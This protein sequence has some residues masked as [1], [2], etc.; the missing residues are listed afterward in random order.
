MRTLLTIWLLG[1]FSIL[2][3]AQ[4]F[5]L[6]TTAENG[7]IEAIF[8]IDGDGIMEYIADT[9][10]VYDGLTHNLKYTL[11]NGYNFQWFDFEPARNPYSVFP[12]IDFNFDGK[13]DLMMKIYGQDNTFIVF[14]IVNNIVLFEFNSP[15][16]RIEFNDLIDIDGDNELELVI[17]GSS[18]IWPNIIYK[19]Y[20][21]STGITTA[22]NE[23]NNSEAPTGFNLM[24]NYPNPFNPSTTIRYSINSPE[25][26]SI[27]IYDITGQLIKEIIKEHNQS[28]DYEV[29]WDG[30]DNY[31]YR[32]S[33]GAYFY[34]IIASDYSEAKKM[35]LLK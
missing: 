3:F 21:F 2:S 26:V 1:L 31:G 20:I 9:I 35:I 17:T 16:E 25:T 11:P 14:D 7:R 28:G 5:Q 30:N 32:V 13:R 22:V 10:H 15:E 19:T 8:D 12:H 23:S 29:N 27:K 33:S 24:Q 34:Q 6:E 18:G 4:Q